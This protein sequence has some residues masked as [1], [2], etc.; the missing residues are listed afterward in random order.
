MPAADSAL[1][2]KLLTDHLDVVRLLAG[3][4]DGIA[5]A[6]GRLV[7]TLR[8]G[9]KIMLCGNGGSA[10]DAQHIA[11]ELVGRFETSRRGL[12]ALALTTDTS[13]LTSVG[14]DYGFDAVFSRQVEAWARPGDC[15]IA[16]STSGNS[17]N[18]LLAVETARGLGCH[19]IG[20]LGG[21]GGTIAGIVDQ[22]LIA[23][24]RHTARVQECHGLIGHIWCAQIDSSNL[25][26]P[27][28]AHD[29]TAGQ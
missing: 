20:L 29:Q 15:L 7:E 6:G 9:G 19:C 28:N 13:I 23:P 21:D 24:T 27:Q 2:S 25:T 18:V 16:I 5:E 11:A 12:P 14:N 1:V 17:R 26:T 3:Q 8:A 4:A 10:A 22:A